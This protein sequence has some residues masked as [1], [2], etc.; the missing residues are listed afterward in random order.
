MTHFIGSLFGGEGPDPALQAAQRRQAESAEA[1]RED[2][3]RRRR[4]QERAGAGRRRG[5]RLTSFA[6]TGET[7]VADLSDTLGG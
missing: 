7:G 1:E 4:A 2:L 6:D 3:E 5:R